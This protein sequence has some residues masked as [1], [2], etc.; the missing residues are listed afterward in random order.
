MS[1]HASELGKSSASTSA[2]TEKSSDD[3]ISSS[4]TALSTWSS[5]DS[6]ESVLEEAD[7]PEDEEVLHPEG[8]EEEAR[9]DGGEVLVPPDVRGKG[10]TFEPRVQVF[11]VT[12]KS[13]LDHRCVFASG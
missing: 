3:D 11:L 2:S 8:Q 7:P 6:V 13:E 12:H 5:F 4:C 9:S 10:V 1:D